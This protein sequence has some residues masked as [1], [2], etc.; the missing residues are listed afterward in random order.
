MPAKIFFLLFFVFLSTTG[1]RAQQISF[2]DTIATYNFH[3]IKINKTGMEVLGSWGLVNIA[4]GSIGYFTT[5]QDETKY[6]CEMTALWGVVNTGIAAISL[7]G[8]KNELTARMDYEQSYH[9]YLANKKLYLINAGL[10]VVYIGAGVGLSAYSQTTKNNQAIY[11]GF[12][13]SIVIQGIFLLLFDNIMFS[14][15]QLDNSKWFRIMNEI[16]FTNKTV[17][18]NY[19][20]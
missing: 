18:F 20:F 9:S 13:K 17:G 8:I 1:L 16:R 5:G 11:S 10:D 7:A 15:H 2:K 3:K 14:T 6:F 4:G 19:S 12:G